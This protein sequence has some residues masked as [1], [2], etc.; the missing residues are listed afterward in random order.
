MI[1]RGGAFKGG[2]EINNFASLID[3]PPT[4]LAAAGVDIPDDFMGR[5][6]ADAL[7]KD[8]GWE[9]EI[10]TQ[11]SEDKVAR[12]I[13][14]P[15]YKYAVMSPENP[16]QVGEADEYREEFLYDLENDPFE[17]NNL[18]K[19]G[20]FK[21]EREELAKILVRHMNRAGEEAKILC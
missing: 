3:L 18:I 4:I 12:C 5:P 20:E 15:K 1:I 16:W 19:S 8:C 14:T 17:Q 10:Y 6:L 9:N 21:S 11:I 2:L 7:N 13:R